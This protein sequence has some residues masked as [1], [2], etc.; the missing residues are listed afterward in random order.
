M[1]RGRFLA[2]A[3]AV[4]LAFAG[5]ARAQDAQALNR[6]GTEL[7]RLN[8]PGALYAYLKTYYPKFFDVA[9]KA[10]LAAV[11]DGKVD[12]ATFAK[13]FAAKLK[14][15]GLSAADAGLVEAD[16]AGFEKV[17][18][19]L[20]SDR[21]QPRLGLT[22]EQI[23]K[24]DVVPEL[25]SGLFDANKH[26]ISETWDDTQRSSVGVHF[27]PGKLVWFN[28]SVSVPELGIKAGVPLTDA[29]KEA[30]AKLFSFETVPGAK[31]PDGTAAYPSDVGR[32]V[33]PN[34][35]ILTIINDKGEV[36]SDLVAK[37]GGPN[38]AN[39]GRDGR[40]DYSEA[41][42]DSEISRN[43]SRAGVRNY[44]ALAVI[45][46]DGLNGKA[47]TIRAPRTMM[48]H[49]NFDALSPD[50]LKKTL[51]HLTH[52]IAIREGLASLS[53]KD[54]AKTY[55]PR[56]SGE[57]WGLLSGLGLEHG[58][59]Y[60]RDNHGVG[61]TVDWGW[62]ALHDSNPPD[63]SGH[64]WGELEKTLEEVNKILGAADK[65]VIDDAKKIF[66]EA[67]RQG[68]D[69]GKQEKIRFAEDDLKQ[70]DQSDLRTLASNTTDP[71]SAGSLSYGSSV[72]DAIARMRS[73][74]HTVETLDY[75]RLVGLPLSQL[76]AMAEHNGITLP[77]G[78]RDRADV[79]AA[80]TGKQASL[81]RADLVAEQAA[82]A[83]ETAGFSSA[84]RG[85]L[86]ARIADATSVDVAADGR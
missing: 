52:E 83:S 36:I 21:S 85:R 46:P 10:D 58:S 57:N 5:H 30:V 53:I 19:T 22:A 47:I 1:K 68:Q 64:E 12:Q 60:T 14:A 51:E 29:Q 4:T 75:A 55:L 2:L 77:K 73:S 8:K 48:R 41:L 72:T 7:A 66:D 9:D 20:D 63:Q 67:F 25:R 49:N 84:L 32:A 16:L 56:I 31:N 28:S 35:H 45:Q 13:E 76:E 50:E 27:I 44:D 17:L 23:K 24:G 82:T 15:A 18:K 42:M 11:L 6:V 61:E 37:G 71:K 34:S 39:T 62:A 38:K 65:V 74:G 80:I 59:S 43:I 69:K 79:V 33:N 78:S 86:D 40:L 81:V 3:L 26:W 70:M 54:W